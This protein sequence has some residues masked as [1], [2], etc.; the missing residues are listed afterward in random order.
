MRLDR[1]DG[2]V[3]ANIAHPRQLEQSVDQKALIAA[4]VRHHH[5]QEKIRLAG[6]QVRSNDF[7][8]RQ[9]RLLKGLGRRLV[10]TLDLDPDKHRQAQAHF[11]TV[12][13]GR[14]ALDQPRLLQQPYPAQTG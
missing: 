4:Q 1:L 9:Y 11:V 2:E 8:Q 13:L 7:R 6:H 10:M 12:Q 14:I 3:A 5:L